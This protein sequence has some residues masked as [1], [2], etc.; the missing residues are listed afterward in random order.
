MSN[1]SLNNGL[2][3]TPHNF[4]TTGNLSFYS[5][6][7][8]QRWF[9]NHFYVFHSALVSFQSIHSSA[10]YIRWNTAHFYLGGCH[11]YRH[12]SFFS[13]HLICSTFLLSTVYWRSVVP[14]HS[15]TVTTF[16]AFLTCANHP[17][18]RRHRLLVFRRQCRR[19][20]M[21]HLQS[22]LLQRRGCVPHHGKF[23]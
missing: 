23:F 14:L 19:Q 20:V 18:H 10:A 7:F 6:V 21:W 4:G 13:V 8:R 16:D 12:F 3:S 11:S 9:I 22:Q 5:Q 2:F 17:F 1:D 15:T